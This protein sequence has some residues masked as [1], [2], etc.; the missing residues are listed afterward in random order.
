MNL[1]AAF[2]AQEAIQ[3]SD[4][5]FMV[6]RGGVDNF[7]VLTFPALLHVYVVLRFEADAEESRQ[8]Y[9]LR[10]RVTH[11]TVEG[12]WQEIPIAF[13]EPPSPDQKSYLNLL[14]NVNFGVRGPGPGRVEVAIDDVLIAPAL[15]FQVNQMQPPPGFPLPPR[16]AG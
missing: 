14:M 12:S 6:W 3:N 13:K 10:M 5:T 16:A 8:L 4:G 11:Q 15:A 9:R 2:L 7:G 1:R